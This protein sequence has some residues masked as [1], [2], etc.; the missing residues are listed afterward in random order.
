LLLVPLEFTRILGRAEA[1]AL[2][3]VEKIPEGY[4]FATD[5]CTT[6]L[7][8]KLNPARYFALNHFPGCP[9]FGTLA[10]PESPACGIPTRFALYLSAWIMSGD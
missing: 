2:A 7:T 5:P 1:M 3:V 9:F 4:P 10:Y 6:V 8:L